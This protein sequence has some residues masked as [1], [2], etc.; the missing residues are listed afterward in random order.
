MMYCLMRI[1]SWFRMYGIKQFESIMTLK[2]PDWYSGQ[3]FNNN[4]FRHFTS[5]VHS[6]SFP[7]T[8]NGGISRTS[9]SG[10]GGFSG[11]GGGGGGGGSW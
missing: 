11:G 5:S 8:G 2:K 10:G 9:S 1:F 3:R 4:T 6:A 7:S